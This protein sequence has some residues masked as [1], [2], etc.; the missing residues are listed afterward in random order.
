MRMLFGP[1]I[2]I[3]G[4]YFP[5]WIPSVLFGVVAGVAL[6]AVLVGV[7][8][9]RWI[10]LPGLFYL[11]TGASSAMVFWLLLFSGATM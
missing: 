10:P 7:G 5:G 8:I 3:A 9:A 6:Y 4:S 11:M 2:D 1:V